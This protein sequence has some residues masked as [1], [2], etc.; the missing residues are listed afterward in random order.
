MDELA[1]FLP[2]LPLWVSVPI[3]VVAI[4]VTLWPKILQ[5]IT[6]LSAANRAFRREKMRLELLKLHY[7]IE[8]LKKEKGLDDRPPSASEMAPTMPSKEVLPSSGP[9]KTPL[10]RRQQFVFGATGALLPVVLNLLFTDVATTDSPFFWFGLVIRL[11]L[12]GLIAGIAS[13]LL[14]PTLA[15]KTNC[16]LLGLSVTLILTVVIQ[17]Q[18]VR[19]RS[20]P[21][22]T[23]A[24]SANSPIQPT[25]YGGG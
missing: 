4:I 19:D 9:T 14:A 20:V 2:A 7:K 17:A 3:I 13:A 16:F 1:K 15:T 18:S 23:S 6:E 21:I 8:A 25:A 12:F 24:L 5:A 22:R 11:A 10:L